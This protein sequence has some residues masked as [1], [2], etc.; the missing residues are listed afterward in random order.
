VVGLNKKPLRVSFNSTKIINYIGTT[1]VIY[2]TEGIG[3]FYMRPI[4]RRQDWGLWLD[5]L[6]KTKYA[7]CLPEAVS[8]YRY[9]PNSLSSNKLK[10][11]KYHISVYE[12]VLGY[13]KIKARLFF[14]CVSLP[15]FVCKKVAEKIRERLFEE[16]EHCK[17]GDNK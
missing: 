7:Y 5:I 14:Y 15:C 3:K 8:I 11:F 12:Q 1:S 6:K 13:S 17:I 9:T 4:R 2:D 16:R 10:L